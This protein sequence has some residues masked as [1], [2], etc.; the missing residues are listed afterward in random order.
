MRGKRGI[1]FGALVAAIV[2][3][4]SYSLAFP[5]SSDA[6]INQQ[7]SFQG[8]LVNPA[9]GTNIAD[10]NYSI[11]FRIYTSTAPTDAGSACSPG[12][13][14]CMW[15]DTETIAVAGGTFY[16]ALGS[17]GSFPLPGSVNFSTS[18]LYL[19]I[20]VGTDAEMQPRIQFT[21]APYAFNSLNSDNLGGIGAG[22][23]V[24]LGQVSGAVGETDSSANP[25]IYVNKNNATGSIL[26]LQKAGGDVFVVLN[27]GDVT[28][29][30]KYNGNTFTSSGL[31]FGNGAAAA[32][33]SNATY[34]L[35]LT[36]H[37]NS[38]F[39][40][41]AGTLTVQGFAGLT[42]NT[43]GAAASS[44]ISLATG[45]ATTTTAGGISL[46]VG[47]SVS[48]A[49]AITIGISAN[50][51]GKTISIGGTTQTGNITIGQ[52]TATNNIYIGSS[53]GSGN[54]QAIYIGA[55][56]TPGS[57]NT[58]NIGNT[59]AG[60]TTTVYG[61][62]TG[63]NR[64]LTVDDN[65]NTNNTSIRIVGYQTN[66]NAFEI[67]SSAYTNNVVA[68]FDKTG[69]LYLGATG[70]SN[71]QGFLM[72]PFT[73]LAATNTQSLNIM[74]GPSTLSGNTGDLAL[75]SGDATSGKSGDVI[76]D[77]G[78]STVTTQLFKLGATNARAITLG[79]NTAA[80]TVAVLVGNTNTSGFSVQATGSN[81]IFS[82]DATAN[83][84][85]NVGN[86]TNGA[87]F[88]NY[89]SAG[90]Q[91]IFVANAAPTVDQVNITN[92]GQPV[93]TANVN[94]LSVDYFGGAAAVEAAGMRID[95]TPGTTSGGTWSGMRIVENTAA[96]S[97][98]NS[99]GL[100]LEGGGTGTGNSYGVEVASGWDIG[101]DVQSGGLQLAAQ[102]NPSTPTAGTLRVYARDIAGRVMPKWLG[103]SGVDTPF[104]AS[105][106]F[107]RVSMAIPNGV[108]SCTTGFTLLGLALAGGGTCSAPAP[109][110]T[111]LKTSIR[112]ADY[113]TGAT[114]GT[115]TYQRASTPQVWRG[116]AAGLG[117]FFFTTRFGMIATQTNNRV[118]VGMNDIV[119]NPGNIDY[120]TSN[121]SNKIGREIN[122]NTGNWKFMTNTAGSLPTV[123]DLGATMPVNT[124][125]LFEL[126]LFSAPNG[127]SIGYRVTD[128]TTGG[129][130]SGSVNANLPSNTVFLSPFYYANNNAVG[131]AVT[132]EHGG[133]Y[134][135]SD[136]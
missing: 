53:M 76:I 133:W 55:S 45:N 41:D 30:G 8:K 123:I 19:G 111:N 97:G 121:V 118:F 31:Q 38:I 33:Q 7:I 11:R 18:G 59:A 6:A 14:T 113:S 28:A 35:N 96:A 109:T 67:T 1:W 51:P 90:S 29:A 84:V 108:A 92:S 127:T 88:K 81:Q 128:I 131:A 124:T 20:K 122:V 91:A 89:Q 42:L 103:P 85:V 77:N 66:A 80:T 72:T 16:Y 57:I 22:G 40:T 130:V 125:D 54:T 26:E 62:K 136:N 70:A 132:L 101:I 64:T 114:A 79:N 74:T 60:S 50:S 12:T 135:E 39:S 73:S 58:V 48:G 82:V 56:A 21:A 4:F 86:A 106:G 93:T 110:T 32:V 120:S 115:S 65:G 5:A 134:L 100:K 78:S 43:P 68:A 116:N 13:N 94:A 2:V 75:Q 126:V 117:G 17:N 36:G 69:K 37:N 46:D 34:G 47:T 95:Y 63:T 3:A 99:Y 49:P 104:Q 10:G 105:L 98:V 107:N 112:R 102:G 119:A 27:N 129:Q 9:D 71:P 15:E 24:Q 52:S 87:S 44:S 23:Y 61:Q 25:S 83:D